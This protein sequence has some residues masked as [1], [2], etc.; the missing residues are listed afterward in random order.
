MWHKIYLH[1]A[2]ETGPETTNQPRKRSLGWFNLNKAPLN[3][4]RKKPQ[5]TVNVDS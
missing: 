3:Y 4:E 1:L 2:W 5:S